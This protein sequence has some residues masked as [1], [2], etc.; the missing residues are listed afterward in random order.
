[1]S[2][3]N[4]PWEAKRDALSQHSKLE[5]NALLIQ[6]PD[7]NE[8]QIVLRGRWLAS[9]STLSGRAQKATGE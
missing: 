4:N 6:L 1:M 5:L 3:S 7:F 9:T 8:E 2:L